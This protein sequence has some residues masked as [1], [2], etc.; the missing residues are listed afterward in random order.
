MNDWE[1]EYE[2]DLS[3]D[4]HGFVPQKSKYT[5]IPPSEDL[6]MFLEGKMDEPKPAQ[7]LLTKAVEITL[8]WSWRNAG[9]S[10][11][12]TGLLHCASETQVI[13]GLQTKSEFSTKCCAEDK[14]F[15][16]KCIDE[17]VTTKKGS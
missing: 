7:R 3:E 6:T 10:Q 17:I 11:I 1:Y 8:N 5:F 2:Y 14:Q 15:A 9:D 16:H 13:L 4:F 12:R